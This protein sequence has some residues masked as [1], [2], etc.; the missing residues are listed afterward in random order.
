MNL[1]DIEN[2]CRMCEIS[3]QAVRDVLVKTPCGH[4]FHRFCLEDYC[5]GHPF[6]PVCE[7]HLPDMS[8]VKFLRDSNNKIR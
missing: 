7:T 2:Q 6:C 8:A 1:F 5:E 3:G 4:H